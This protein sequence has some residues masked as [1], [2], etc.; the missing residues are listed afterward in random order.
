MKKIK[1]KY[2][3]III[4]ILIGLVIS[5]GGVYAAVTI[6]GSNVTYANSSS[7]LTSTNVQG[8]IDELNTKTDIRKMSNF[9]VAYKY[10][11]ATSTKCITGEEDTCVKTTCY[12]TKTS[13]S[14]PAGTIIKYKV[15][16]TMAVNFHVMFD[17]GTTLT[18]QSQKNTLYN[19]AW[20]GVSTSYTYKNGPM[21][22]LPLLESITAGWSN[23]N[24][25]TYTLG[26]TVF[27]TNAYTG[28]ST[29][30]SCT[31]N[32]YTMASRSSKARLITVQEAAALGCTETAKS[33]PAWLMNYL[34]AS[35]S[36]GGTIN[37]T[38]TRVGTSNNAYWIM[39]AHLESG[40][41]EESWAIHYNGSLIHNGTYGPNAGARA[42]VVVSK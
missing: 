28:C 42:V 11:T 14:C 12:M 27:K 5:V 37:D 24:T 39:N 32:L 4:G 7:G 9:V 2:I 30:N 20:Y 34:A 26:T 6:T 21:T 10:S 38:T 13:G 23:V 25:Q 8:A 31:S 29:Y 17:N 18:M 36:Y 19:S 41:Y 15:N 16:D 22:I 35:T 33:C 1:K 40:V 3:F